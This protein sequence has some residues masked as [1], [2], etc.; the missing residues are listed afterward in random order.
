MRRA[1]R[2]LRSAAGAACAP[3]APCGAGSGCPLPS[4]SSPYP[5]PRPAHSLRSTATERA[6]ADPAARRRPAVST[7][8]G[9]QL[10][11]MATAVPG[12]ASRALA[13]R[14]AAVESR[15]ITQVSDAGPIFWAAARGANVRD[16]DGNVYVDLTAGFSVAAAGHANARVVRALARQ[17]E[18]LPHALGDVHPA[19]AKVALL[20]RLAALAP[21]DL[22][23][24]ILASAGA[25][26]VEAAL[27]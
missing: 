3:P 23:V 2:P 14:L 10:P 5:L 8:F 4:A 20:E 9:E 19:D 21:G 24:T 13:E 27:K 26:A 16:A 15:N 12:P 18:R 17:A 7:P 22:G 6:S 11:R 1:W 25:E